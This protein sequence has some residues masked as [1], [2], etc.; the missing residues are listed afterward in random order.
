MGGGGGN[1]FVDE[2]SKRCGSQTPAQCAAG[3]TVHHVKQHSFKTRPEQ[4][5][6][7]RRSVL[8]FLCFRIL[9]SVDRAFRFGSCK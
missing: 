6:K 1:C 7:T 5:I 3:A 4:Q 9:C 8:L 2:I